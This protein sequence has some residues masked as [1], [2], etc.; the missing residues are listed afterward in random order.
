MNK[1]HEIYLLYLRQNYISLISG[2]LL[3]CGLIS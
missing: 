1:I 2:D 3:F